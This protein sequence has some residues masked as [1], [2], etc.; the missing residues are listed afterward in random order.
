MVPR[1]VRAAGGRLG[2]SRHR[3]RCGAGDAARGAR[4]KVALAATAELRGADDEAARYYETVWRTDQTLCQR[5]IRAGE[6]ACPGGRP[7]RRDRRT[8]PGPARVSALHRSTARPRSRYC[9]TAAT[10]DDLD[11]QTLVDAGERA[12]A[13]TLESAAKR[14][15]IRLRVLARRIGAGC[16]RGTRPQ[17]PRLLGADFDE[18]GIRVGME[19]CYR[20]AGARDDRYVGANRVGGEGKCD[21]AEDPGMTDAQV[22]VHAVR[23]NVVPAPTGSARTAAQPCP[24]SDVSPYPGRAG[25]AGAASVRRLRQRDLR[26]RSTAPYAASGAPSRIAT[27][28]SS[29]GV[30]LITDRG[31]EHARNED[32]AAAGIVAGAG[33]E[34]PHAIAAAVCDGVSTSG[35]AHTRRSAASKAGVEAMLTALAASRKAR[36]GGAGGTGGCGEGSR[37]APGAGDGSAS[38]PS[39]TYTAAVVVPTSTGDGADRR[40]QR[41]RQ[42]GVLAARTAR[43][44]TTPDGRRL[45]GAAN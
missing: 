42:Q 30:V 13:L 35:D 27:R 43:A 6:A 21:P 33:G 44:A 40:R 38:A 3:F 17:A 37:E 2:R 41:R 7:G 8:G 19:L 14:A 18:R 16:R 31:L 25:A 1:P 39:C 10:A 45:R 4:P 9:S 32:A 26:R 23:P 20:D 28:A 29:R 15:T 12:S 34:R 22:D 36:V 5:R 24:R 11:E